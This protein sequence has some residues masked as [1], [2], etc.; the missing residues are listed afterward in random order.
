HASERY[1]VRH[2][3]YNPRRAN[4]LRRIDLVHIERKSTKC[5]S[6][7][8]ATARADIV[9]RETIPSSDAPCLTD[10]DGGRRLREAEILQMGGGAENL[11][12][13]VC[14]PSR[15][16]GSSRNL[17]NVE[18]VDLVNMRRLNRGGSR[19]RQVDDPRN[20]L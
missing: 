17:S 19:L 2:G 9:K 12:Q 15:L 14:L 20:V 11:H 3:G 8:E 18:G 6:V 16:D 7:S 13:L 5:Y 1:L 4:V 10:S